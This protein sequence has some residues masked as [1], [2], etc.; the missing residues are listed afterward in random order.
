[1]WPKYIF[2]WKLLT[3]TPSKA[4]SWWSYLGRTNRVG[5]GCEGHSCWVHVQTL[6]WQE[7]PSSWPIGWC[8]VCSKLVFGQVISGPPQLQ[9]MMLD[10]GSKLWSVVSDWQ[11]WSFRAS[12]VRI[13]FDN[14]TSASNLK[15]FPLRNQASSNEQMENFLP[16]LML[17]HFQF[18]KWL[19]MHVV[20][21]WPC[22][23]C[24]EGPL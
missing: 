20:P 21:R 17:Q 12:N 2:C 4:G 10:F 14:G 6:Q 3:I 9:Q 19:R 16:Y 1:M 5:W 23:S 7:Y 22:N 11:W 8:Q 13:S 24:D 18:G 15:V